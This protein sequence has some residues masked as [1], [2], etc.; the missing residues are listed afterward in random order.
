LIQF[1]VTHYFFNSANQAEFIFSVFLR[2]GTYEAIFED[3]VCYLTGMQLIGGRLH[4][5][6]IPY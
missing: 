6:E 1:C 2:G 3:V 4:E 5:T